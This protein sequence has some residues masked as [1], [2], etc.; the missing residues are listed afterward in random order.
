MIIAWIRVEVVVLRN[1]WEVIQTDFGINCLL[2]T[3]RRERMVSMRNRRTLACEIV[4][5]PFTELWNPGRGRGPGLSSIKITSLA[6]EGC[7]GDAV[8]TTKW[9]C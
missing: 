4:V 5:K 2:A 9:R 3:R 8:E 6:L 7:D 1:I